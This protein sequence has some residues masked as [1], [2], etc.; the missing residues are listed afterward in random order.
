MSESINIQSSQSLSIAGL[1]KASNDFDRIMLEAVEAGI[2]SGRSMGVIEAYN[3]L[4]NEGYLDAA[5]T[6]MDLINED[7][8]SRAMRAD[9]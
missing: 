8:E 5:E 7:T 6:L 4:V 2:E 3:L 9:A 1:I